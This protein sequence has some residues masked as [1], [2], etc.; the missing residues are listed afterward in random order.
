V[1]SHFHS[2]AHS[3]RFL[4]G[5]FILTIPTLLASLLAFLVDIL[6]FIPH[7]KWGGWIVLCATI[8][9]IVASLVTCCMRRTLVSRKAR[10]K[11]IAENAEMS[12]ENYFNKRGA[13]IAATSLPRAES[14]P[15]LSGSPPLD[16]SATFGTSFDMKPSQGSDDRT[17]LNP[18]NNASVRGGNMSDMGYSDP[19]RGTPGTGGS[20]PPRD[21]YGNILPPNAAGLRH[22]NSEGSVGSN[23]SNGG[24]FY[25][26]GGRG[27][28]P[29]NGRG[30]YPP[31]GGPMMRGGP[32]MRG[33]PPPGWNGRGRGG[34]PP[35]G[36]M[37][38]R[39]GL[40]P[41]GYG[42]DRSYLGGP[43]SRN[44]SPLP[45][46]D[47]PRGMSP[48]GMRGDPANIGQA[49]EMDDRTGLPSPTRPDGPP[50]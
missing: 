17:P 23:R 18:S 30:G 20:S 27:G 31:R 11:R 29:P 12:G 46:G 36:P 21:Q 33:G 44:Q 3:P 41:P 25:A 19:G 10:R 5:L 13:E 7:V 8:I 50:E 48:A 28:Y 6:L 40:A 37:T 15:P 45:Y 38:G 16:K 2:P 32:G 26:R 24:P 39:G 4:L 42:Q 9:L 22:Q 1:A 35:G 47:A 43:G 34:M 49:V 14:P